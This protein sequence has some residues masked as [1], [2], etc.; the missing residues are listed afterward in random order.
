[1]V[2]RPNVG[3]DY[4]LPRYYVVLDRAGSQKEAEDSAARLRRDFPEAAAV[5]QGAGFLIV[6]SPQPKLASE[7]LAVASRAKQR[8]LRPELLRAP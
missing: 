4:T 5:K 3:I 6:E 1:L 8:S 2:Q 7:A